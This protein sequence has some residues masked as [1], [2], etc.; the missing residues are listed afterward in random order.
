M[1]YKEISTEA[2]LKLIQWAED[3]N[4]DWDVWNA[5]ESICG[6]SITELGLARWPEDC[7]KDEKVLADY[8]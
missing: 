2:A 1:I 4:I 7:T 5:E 8:L 6:A 3:N